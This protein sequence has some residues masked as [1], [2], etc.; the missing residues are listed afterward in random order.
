AGFL[1]A[2]RRPRSIDWDAP[3]PPART[4][5]ELPLGFPEMRLPAALIDRLRSPG[6]GWES[7]LPTEADL[8]DRLKPGLPPVGQHTGPPEVAEA[9]LA[10]QDTMQAFLQTQ[11][12][13]LAAYLSGSGR[14]E[15]LPNGDGVG[16][17]MS[18]EG[19]RPT[20]SGPEP[21][22]WVGAVRR[23]VAGSEIE[24]VYLL[25]SRDDPIAEHHTLGGRRVSAVD[26]S[27][28]GLPALPFAVMAEMAAQV[29]ALLVSPGRV[30]TGLEQVRAH[31]WVRYEEEPVQLELR[32]RRVGSTADHRIWVGIFNR[33]PD[34]RRE[35]ARPAFEAVAVFGA[36][37][38]APPPAMPWALEEP[39]PSRFTAESLYGEQW[40]FHGPPFQALVRVG[41]F[42]AQGIEGTLCVRPWEPV[43]RPDQAPH[44]HTDIIIVD[45]FTHLLGCWGL[46]YLTEGGDVVFPLRMEELQMYGD[47]PPVGTEVECRI[48]IQEIQRHRVRVHAEILRPDG[49]V[50]MRLRDWEDWRFHWPRRYRDVFRQPRDIFVGEELPLEG[51][52]RA[53]KAVWLAPPADM[54]RPVWRDVLEQTQLGPAERAAHLAEGGGERRRAHRLW[55]I[56]AAKEAA[57]RLW[58]AQGRPATYPAD[59]AIVTEQPGRPRLIRVDQPEDDTL[60]AIAIAHAEGV[61][62]AIAAGDPAG[63]IGIDVQAIPDRSD[64]LELARLGC[65]RQAAAR[66]AGAELAATEV[67]HAEETAGLV[68]V[69]VEPDG[70]GRPLRVVSGRRG[71]VAWAWTLGEGAEP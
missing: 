46:D 6:P 39:R 23:L 18:A 19:G 59:L 14:D 5:V 44:L 4:L 1:Y 2:R 11:H 9:L 56:I 13:V 17:Q 20:R 27:L 58:Q 45:S 63:R 40:L 22:P 65:A 12:E 34:G 25:D 38:A 50:W 61:A 53:A 64:G 10:F 48:A 43:L 57:R 28:K 16:W 31:K 37:G 69:R 29:A 33:G 67:V 54:G 21:G 60:P 42:S 51:A 3:E 7:R 49:T 8:P 70:T 52:S 36:A 68:H 55:G 32:G 41:S 71:D 30:L 62:V 15:P 26:P 47:R 35:A 66:A 24:S